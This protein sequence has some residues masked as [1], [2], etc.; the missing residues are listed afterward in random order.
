MIGL[1]TNVLL[2]LFVDDAPEQAGLAR[3]LMSDVEARGELAYV[4]P[5]V[6]AEFCWALKG[7]YKAD[8]D[9]V[10]GALDEI[11]NSAAFEIDDR[12]SVEAAIETWRTGKADF[13]DYLIAAMARSAGAKTTY[14]FDKDAA[15][16]RPALT[17]LE[18]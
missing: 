17:L 16:T 15:A 8:K 14:T 12:A 6:L 18:A 5:L 10:L 1:D 13:A 4:S 9:K 3:R 2:R 11:I 7:P